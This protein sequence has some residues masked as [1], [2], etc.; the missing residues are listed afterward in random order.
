MDH[1]EVKPVFRTQVTD[2]LKEPRKT[3]EYFT[4]YEYTT[5]LATRAKQA[6]RC[7]YGMLR[8]ER[9]NRESYPS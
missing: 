4:K 7:L 2:A 5:L 9:L 6:T 1:P 8:N 3:R